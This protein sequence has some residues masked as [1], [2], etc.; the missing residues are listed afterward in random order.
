MKTAVALIFALGMWVGASC[1]S[2]QT[3]RTKPANR[4]VK[5]T[6]KE[7]VYDGAWWAKAEQE[8]RLGFLEG[9]S[10][11]LEWDAHA[12]LPRAID[13]LEDSITVYY[14]T[15]P[16]ERNIAVITVWQKVS[17]QGPPAEPGPPGGEVWTNP[18]GFLDG[19]WWRETSEE[20]NLGFVE[21]YLL[22]TST[23]VNQPLET[24]SRPASYY[25]DEIS[26]YVSLHPKADSMAVANILA[27]F[28]DRQK[29]KT[30]DP[31]P[32]KP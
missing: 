4:E 7:T 30:R 19:Q 31:K 25:V 11:C 26:K 24:Y 10:D 1:I 20:R 5:K 2:A 17:T 22:C 9:Y 15:H 28:H 8:E 23:C 3:A 13:H 18:H 12:K 29:S 21:G 6:E 27:L 32:T 14:K 16:D